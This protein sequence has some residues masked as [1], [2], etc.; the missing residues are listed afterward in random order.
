MLDWSP[1][2]R[3]VPGDCCTVSNFGRA[4]L[5][6]AVLRVCDLRVYRANVGRTVVACCARTA[7]GHR[8]ADPERAGPPPRVDAHLR[9]G[10]RG[11]SLWPR[12]A[13]GALHVLRA[14]L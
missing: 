7:V 2:L 10:P 6:Y 13:I 8:S 5:G 1:L 12:S 11:G 14:A 9:V 4:R 3:L